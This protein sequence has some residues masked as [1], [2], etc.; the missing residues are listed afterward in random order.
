MPAAMRG[1]SGGGTS[2]ADAG[3][4]TARTASRQATR[5]GRGWR[6]VRR[7]TVRAF[8]QVGLPRCDQIPMEA[9]TTLPFA[10]V[11]VVANRLHVD[12][13]VVDDE[14]AVRLARETA[15][16][17][18]LV[19]DAIGIGARILDREQTGAQVEVIKAEL[20]KATQTAGRSLD[21]TATRMKAEV[22]AKLA[23]LLGP[24]TGHLA[25]AL[26]RH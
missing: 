26:A 16:P 20:E 17:A 19:G 2:C 15:D 10:Q 24:E 1:A 11:R 23:E 14:C 12:G 3:N 21:E 7:V 8:R 25:R 13:L 22:D 5:A 6:T 18:K 9:A 4:A